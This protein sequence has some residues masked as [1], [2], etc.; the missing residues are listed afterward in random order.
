MRRWSWFLACGA[1]LV[2]ACPGGSPQSDL[3]LPG[4]IAREV[5]EGGSNPLP[6]EVKVGNRGNCPL[7][8]TAS[9][10][11]ASGTP[12]LAVSPTTSVVVAPDAQATFTISFNIAGLQPGNHAG[13]IDF[14]GTCTA[15]QQDARG[16]PAHLP[17]NLRITPVGASISLDTSSVFVDVGAVKDEWVPMADNTTLNGSRS[18]H[19]AVWTGREMWAYGGLDAAGAK[20]GVGGKYDPLTNSWSGMPTPN[21][22]GPRY[23]HTAVWTGTEMIIWGGVDTGPLDTGA[24][25]APPWTT[26]TT[27]G[28]PQA[29]GGHT[30]VWTGTEMIVFGGYN[31]SDALATGG[32]YKPSPESWTSLPTGGAP[33]ARYWHSAVWTGKHMLIWG[34][35]DAAGQVSGGKKYDPVANDWSPMASGGPERSYLISGWTGSRWLLYGGKVGGTAYADGMMYSPSSNTW[36]EIP[37]DFARRSEIAGAVWTG[38]ELLV[39]GGP[40]A[41]G[42]RFNPQNGTWSDM[43]MVGQPP[44]RSAVSAVWTGNSMIVYG[45]FNA[46]LTQATGGIYR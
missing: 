44:V 40:L 14:R 12:W 25:L 29:R 24:R 10:V 27:S 41:V 33:A 39:W 23:Q 45:G 37:A 15:T 7:G 2:T 17:V 20:V 42:R 31:L 28:A 35:E 19:T 38:R 9:A 6:E 3:V 18:H 43:T 46:T 11:T 5:S 4:Q 21:T 32:R 13:Y 34:G 16:S 30:A 1:A 26:M 36:E 8:V 22:P